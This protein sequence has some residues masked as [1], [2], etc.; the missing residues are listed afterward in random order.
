[1]EKLK[2]R[3]NFDLKQNYVLMN[4]YPNTLLL[5]KK[6]YLLYNFW[7]KRREFFLLTNDDKES[8]RFFNYIGFLSLNFN[9]H[10]KNK[11]FDYFNK[12]SSSYLQYSDFIIKNYIDFNYDKL[13][14]NC[15][16]SLDYTIFDNIFSKYTVNERKKY[17]YLNNNFFLKEFI[18]KLS[19]KKEHL[20]LKDYLLR[21]LLDYYFL[22]ND[23]YNDKLNIY[24]WKKIY[25]YNLYKKIYIYIFLY[26]KKK[27]KR[28]I[29]NYYLLKNNNIF[30]NKYLKNNNILFSKYLKNNNIFFNKYL[31]NNKKKD[32]I[33]F[34]NFFQYLYFTKR[35]NR[36][37]FGYKLRLDRRRASIFFREKFSSM[38]GHFF[39]KNFK[40]KNFY[41]F[42]NKFN[43]K[44]LST[45]T[46][47]RLNNIMYDQRFKKKILSKSSFLKKKKRMNY[48]LFKKLR[49]FYYIP[50]PK[51]TRKQ[52]YK[53]FKKNILWKL[54]RKKK[55]KAQMRFTGTKFNLEFYNLRNRYKNKMK[56]LALKKKTTPLYHYY[57][58]KINN[59]VKFR[60]NWIKVKHYELPYYIFKKYEFNIF[61]KKRDFLEKEDW[62]IF[63]FYRNLRK[64][65]FKQ[66]KKN[67][68]YLYKNR[69]TKLRKLR[70]LKFVHF[71]MNK[72]RNICLKKKNKYKR[73]IK[74]QNR[75]FNN[76]WGRKKKAFW[77]FIKG[78][79]YW[80]DVVKFKKNGNKLFNILY[81]KEN[82]SEFLLLMYKNFFFISIEFI[83]LFN[84]Y[85]LDKWVIESKK[86]YIFNFI[87]N[88]I[89]LF[90][91]FLILFL[92]FINK[93]NKI[94]NIYKL[95]ELKGLLFLKK[96]KRRLFKKK[97]KL[98]FLK[99]KLK[100]LKKKLKIKKVRLNFKKLKIINKKKEKRKNFQNNHR[101]LYIIRDIIGLKVFT[102][103][104]YNNK[105]KYNKNNYN[106]NNYNKNNYNKNNYNK[107]NYNKNNYNKNNY[108]KN[109]LVKN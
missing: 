50:D 63:K 20:K 109:I 5:N 52:V 81:V 33:N 12:W 93:V 68:L 77:F 6:M 34:K 87:F 57:K 2:E 21:D 55:K 97:R 65:P 36:S 11:H 45:R 101:K 64:K 107:N 48:R 105:W 28:K 66:N 89:Y 72:W 44:K 75:G 59:Y 74:H 83:K 17:Y 40:K 30:F 10:Y 39:Y 58:K 54:K 7:N 102:K 25:Y 103:R 60:G 70:F 26:I 95:S 98:K 106:K 100:F 1:L 18:F 73:Y 3:F 91:L 99:R 19:K 71:L 43:N 41:S 29:F 104:K 80:K 78:L 88:I 79:L 8:R 96:K 47:F 49:K 42:L 61:K 84:I 15:R 108:N 38:I 14:I 16:Y 53:R 13:F 62:N 46:F 76:A 37:I 27:I 82:S 67:W 23:N 86:K 24:N 4:I 92:C 9:I 56:A 31:K 51:K 22:L 90:K 94:R 85:K 35:M 69:G 32:N